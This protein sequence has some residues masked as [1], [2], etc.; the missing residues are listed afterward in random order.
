MYESSFIAAI[1]EGGHM[2][3]MYVCMYITHNLM[4]NVD[5]L[6]VNAIL[7]DAYIHLKLYLFNATLCTIR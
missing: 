4:N 2:S 5:K 3:L 1:V 7:S 6:D